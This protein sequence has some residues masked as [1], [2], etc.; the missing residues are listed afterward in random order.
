M[1]RTMGYLPFASTTHLPDASTSPPLFRNDQR[2]IG[3]RVP[4]AASGLSGPVVGGAD[5]LG[6]RRTRAN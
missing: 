1:D 4:A 5:R 2:T 6:E 3:G